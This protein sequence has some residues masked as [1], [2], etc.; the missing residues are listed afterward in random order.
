VT[1]TYQTHVMTSPLRARRGTTSVAAT[2]TCPCSSP[3]CLMRC[4][5]VTLSRQQ[6]QQQKQTLQVQRVTQ[7]SRFGFGRVFYCIS[8]K[9]NRKDGSRR[10][11][12]VYIFLNII[13]G[14]VYRFTTR[15]SLRPLLS[16]NFQASGKD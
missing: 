5:V 14:T 13:S 15:C 11:P 16:C 12:R 3:P 1:Q 7:L 8:Q 4:S 2:S 6:P 10:H 9:F